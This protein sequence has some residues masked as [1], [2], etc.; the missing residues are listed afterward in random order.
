MP[1]GAMDMWELE[2]AL[3]SERTGYSKKIHGGWAQTSDGKGA[4]VGEETKAEK[5]FAALQEELFEGQRNLRNAGLLPKDK[6]ELIDTYIS[7]KYDKWAS[8]DSTGQGD[9][10]VKIEVRLKR[11]VL[12]IQVKVVR[13]RK[14]QLRFTTCRSMTTN[15]YSSVD[16]LFR[17]CGCKSANMVHWD[18][19]F[20][21]GVSLRAHR[22]RDFAAKL[23]D[24]TRV[25]TVDWHVNENMFKDPQKRK[26]RGDFERKKLKHFARINPIVAPAR[27]LPVPA[28]NTNYPVKRK[29]PK[30][31]EKW[32]EQFDKFSGGSRPSTADK[33]R[34]LSRARSDLADKMIRATQQDLELRL[35]KGNA[36]IKSRHSE[37][38][39]PRTG[40][41]LG[42]HFEPG[43][44]AK[45]DRKGSKSSGP[46]CLYRCPLD[47]TG[48]SRS[49][50]TRPQSASAAV[51]RARDTLPFRM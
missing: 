50:P 30:N 28:S 25:D 24:F 14:R 36:A 3:G 33:R 43:M 44:R 45:N 39:P 51:V 6:L 47:N 29:K 31:K 4:Y 48:A 38:P 46:Q 10:G 34:L 26:A 18:R 2:K 40:W 16:Q 41:L 35:K 5:I 12:E 21:R 7:E 49:R 9:S 19:C 17:G 32:D 37:V 22:Y 15:T 42:K 11:P 20:Y 27:K 1:S 23:D 8:V 13:D